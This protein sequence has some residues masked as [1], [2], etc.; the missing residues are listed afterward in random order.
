MIHSE[1]TKTIVEIQR[2]LKMKEKHLKTFSA[3]S[4]TLVAKGN[5]PKGNS[6][7]RLGNTKRFLALFKGLDLRLVLLR[8]KRQKVMMRKIWHV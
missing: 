4:V 1:H 5:H 7:L 6:V 2:H 8:N 3:S